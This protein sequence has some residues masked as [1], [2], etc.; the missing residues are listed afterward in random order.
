[1]IDRFGH[2][3]PTDFVPCWAIAGC[4]LPVIPFAPCAAATS[5]AKR[6]RE[7]HSDSEP[8]A[9]VAVRPLP[10]ELGDGVARQCQAH[11][12]S[13]NAERDIMAGQRVN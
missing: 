8:G 1:M 2:F 4:I 10:G 11:V 13:R 6:G 12:R 3:G 9:G 7:Q 5:K